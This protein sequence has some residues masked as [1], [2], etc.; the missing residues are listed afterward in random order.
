VHFKSIN[1]EVRLKPNESQE[2]LLKR[3]LKKCKKT[4]ITKEHIEKTLFYSKP[5]QKRRSKRL[6]NKFLR[7]KEKNSKK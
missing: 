7:E 5:S 2:K 6:K 1:V 4:E 3:F